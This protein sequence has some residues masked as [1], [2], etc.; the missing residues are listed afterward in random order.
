MESKYRKEAMN[1]CTKNI[2]K[3]L[4]KRLRLATFTV[5]KLEVRSLK[6]ESQKT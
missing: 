5:E 6:L 2:Q 4:V 1:H 3:N